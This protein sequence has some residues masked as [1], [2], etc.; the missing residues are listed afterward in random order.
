MLKDSLRKQQNSHHEDLVGQRFKMRTVL[1]YLGLDKRSTAVFRVLCD[2]GSITT[3]KKPSILKSSSCGCEQKRIAKQTCE[4]RNTTHG[5]AGTTTYAIWKTMRQ[6]CNDP[7][8]IGYEFYKNITIDPRWDN[9]QNFLDDMGERPKGLTLDRKD[10][11]LGYS[12]E[13]CRWATVKDQALNRRTT[14]MIEY[15]GKTKPLQTWCEE[16][17]LPVEKIRQRFQR[18][19]SADK[20]F[21]T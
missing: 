8:T 13:N 14:V 16:F 10:N 12:P 2:C 5:K 19:W 20:A 3:A 9:Y 4:K 15:R 21:T 17:H 1:E 11:S 6:R 18:G 7:N